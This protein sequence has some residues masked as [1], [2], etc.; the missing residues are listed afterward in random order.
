MPLYYKDNNTWKEFATNPYPVGTLVV[1]QDNDTSP[2]SLVGGTWSKYGV[3]TSPSIENH[4]PNLIQDVHCDVNYASGLVT[5]SFVCADTYGTGQ[6]FEKNRQ[7]Y[8]LLSGLPSSTEQQTSSVQLRV[9]P[10]TG[11]SGVPVIIHDTLTLNI[12]GELYL[13]LSRIYSSPSYFYRDQNIKFNYYTSNSDPF[14]IYYTYKR[15]A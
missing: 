13:N 8:L 10:N 1:N 15:T 5:L 12:A 3:T 4:Y 9:W 6:G 2:A 14:N 11:S 7:S